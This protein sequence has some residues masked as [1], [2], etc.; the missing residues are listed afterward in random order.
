MTRQSNVQALRFLMAVTTYLF[1]SLSAG[2]SHAQ[3]TPLGD[4]YTNSAD[5]T[6]NYGSNVLLDVD[7]AT[8]IAYIQF[9]LSSIPSGATVSQATLKLYVNAVTTAGSFNVNYVTSAWSESTL[10]SS[11]APTQGTTIASDVAITTADKNQYIL[12]NVTSAVQAWLSGSEANDGIAL[13][14]NGS[15]NASFDSKENTTTS[16]PAELDVVF[17][18][19]SGGGISGITTAS[20]SGLT[21][22]GTS[23]TLNLSL[24]TACAPNQILQWNG[25]AWACASA[26]Y[27]TAVYGGTGITVSG[28]PSQ[29]TVGINQDVVPLLSLVNTFHANQIVD[30]NL[31]ATVVTGGSFNIGS[32]LFAFGSY[33][34]ESVFLGF[35]GNPATLAGADTAVGFLALASEANGFSNVAVGNSALSANKTGGNNTAIGFDALGGNAGDNV[36]IGANAL[37]NNT[38]GSFN[39]AAGYQALQSNTAGFYNV[40]FGYNAG[41]AADG[42]NLIGLKNTFLGTGTDLST[43]TISNSTAI[44]VYAEVS[45]SNAIV[46]GCVSGAT[47]GCP[48]S[49]VNVGI[50]TTAPAHLLEVD[51]SVSGP[52]IS[53]AGTASDAA[54]AVNN[55]GSGGRQYW[56]DSASSGS[57]LGSGN[58]GVYDATANETRLVINPS[59]DVGIGITNPSHLLQ[60]SDGA[61]ESGGTWTNASDRNLKE[62]FVPVDG[63]GLLAKLN[64]IPLQTWKYK[65]DDAH[66]R[67]LGP[68]AQDF[69]AA[70]ALG[71]DDKHISTVDEGGVAL[72]AVQELYREG[73][74]KD[75]TIRRQQNQIQQLAEQVRLQQAQIRARE[76]AAHRQQVQ[77]DQL[78]EQVKVIRA[79]VHGNL[80]TDGKTLSARMTTIH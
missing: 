32:N 39:T 28:N 30:G 55:T 9:P 42:T 19:G 79:A 10:D 5:P 33:S 2:L 66:I 64:A 7:G 62:S 14:A 47:F 8:Q 13:V 51:G 46:L 68:M 37:S 6:T 40:A 26:A 29:P 56:I 52:L 11:N 18:P 53:T 20:G 80:A 24:S 23:G 41:F 15:F 74:K 58:F 48:G 25:S 77:I 59:G 61:Y 4:S 35:A 16:H 75:T 72:A 78:A 60:M 44:G 63:A 45:E 36:A 31:T 27:L 71:E 22:G 49:A 67:H 76:K 21:G 43:G 34:T 70:F 54:I 73:L 1:L 3:I 69:R 12:I 17:A 57:G 38:E 50:G 65:T